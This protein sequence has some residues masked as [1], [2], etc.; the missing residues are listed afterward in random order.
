MAAL[1]WSSKME[2]PGPSPKFETPRMKQL[3]GLD[4]HP[5]FYSRKFTWQFKLYPWKIRMVHLLTFFPVKGTTRILCVAFL[6]G[7]SCEPSFVTGKGDNPT[8]FLLKFRGISFR[9]Y[10]IALSPNLTRPCFLEKIA[11][12]GTF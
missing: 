2:P 6:V 3:K 8:Y 12:G 1:L 7:D 4:I 10:E 9:D 5:E 11:L